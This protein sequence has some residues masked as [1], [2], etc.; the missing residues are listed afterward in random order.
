MH[1]P[2]T[3]N[4]WA[5]YWAEEAALFVD[6]QPQYIYHNVEEGRYF[7]SA[8][9]VLESG[10]GSAFVEGALQRPGGVTRALLPP[11]PATQAA[12]E[13]PPKKGVWEGCE[14]GAKAATC[15][16]NGVV[17]FRKPCGVCHVRDI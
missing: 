5:N 11:I 3:T 15:K 13:A 1:K 16:V 9:E 6:D 4:N 10:K 12:C 8:A 14:G 2:Y 17:V 7:L